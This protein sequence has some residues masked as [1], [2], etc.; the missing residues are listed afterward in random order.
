MGLFRSKEFN[1]RVIR[2]THLDS[3]D[4]LLRFLGNEEFTLSAIEL[5]HIVYQSRKFHLDRSSTYK[6]VCGETLSRTR[7]FDS[8]IKVRLAYAHA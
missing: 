8:S 3:F 6:I 7:K 1:E 2:L 4:L 5:K